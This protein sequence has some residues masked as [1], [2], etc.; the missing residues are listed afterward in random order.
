MTW[1]L[2]TNGKSIGEDVFYMD[3][4]EKIA[5]KC[6]KNVFVNNEINNRDIAIDLNSILSYQKCIV[7]SRLYWR[8]I[9]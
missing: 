3:Q 6:K 2:S 4:Y 5:T 7:V 1:K 8:Y 9:D